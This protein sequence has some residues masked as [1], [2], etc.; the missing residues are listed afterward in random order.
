MAR[1]E[2]MVGVQAA[3]SGDAVVRQADGAETVLRPQACLSGDR[4]NFRGVDLLSPPYV[5]RVAADPLE[6]LGVAVIAADGGERLVFRASSCAVLAGDVQRTGW[7]VNDVWDVSGNFE[8]DCR[9]PSGEG[10]TGK[11]TFEHCH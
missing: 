6:G 11:F 5:L 10:L 9:L 4:A 1:L 2:S 8:V 7:R 3:V